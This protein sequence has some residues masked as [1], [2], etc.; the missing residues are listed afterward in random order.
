[1]KREQIERLRGHAAYL[2]IELAK[3]NHPDVLNFNE[4][5]HNIAEAIDAALVIID[6]LP[7]AD[8]W[9]LHRVYGESR[10]QQHEVESIEYRADDDDGDTGLCA[11]FVGGGSAMLTDCHST[12]EAALAAAKEKNTHD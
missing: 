8:V 7:P 3:G 2:R 10:I 11:N 5:N 6:K 9:V 1:M 4:R 12:R